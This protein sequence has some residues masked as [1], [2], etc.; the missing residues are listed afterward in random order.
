MADI[1][2]I[3][4]FF[5]NE[6][7]GGAEIYDDLLISELRLKGHNIVTFKSNEVI[8]KHISFHNNSG[9][10]FFISNFV[11]LPERTKNFFNLIKAIIALLSM[12]INI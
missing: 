9:F 6:V 3:S 11:T 5:V 4:D 12:I 8:D 7:N 2:F 10:V 1:V